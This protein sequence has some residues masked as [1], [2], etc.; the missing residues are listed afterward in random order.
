MIALVASLVL[1]ALST[2]VLGPVHEVPAAETDVFHAING[3]PDS[4]RPFVVPVMFLGA[5]LAIGAVAVICVVVRRRRLAAV[6][7]TAGYGAYLVARL[8][9]LAVGRERPGDLF[10]TI[11]LR[12]EVTGLGFP[13]G[14]SAVSMALA[15][16]VIP[17]LSTRW[18]WGLLVVPAA[19]GFARVYVGAHLPLDVVSGWAIGAVAASAAHLAF[20]VP[21]RTTTEPA[22]VEE[23][24]PSDELDRERVG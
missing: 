24:D 15:L 4:I 5:A 3:L 19:V 20:G 7:A 16:A 9:K 8:A 1:I 6:V 17:Y 11:Q 12:D 18:R 23:G 10:E 14:H 22:V 2:G 21:P 13:S